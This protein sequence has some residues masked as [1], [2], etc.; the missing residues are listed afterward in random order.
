MEERRREII[1]TA[2]RLFLENG[3]DKT[4]VSDI[5]KGM[6]IAQGLVY[7]YFKS[8]AEILY[9]VVEELSREQIAATEKALAD[10]EGSALSRLSAL[11]SNLPELQ[12]CG[13]LLGDGMHDQG[14][15][16][17]CGTQMALAM[18]PLLLKLIKQGNADGS[19]QCEYPGETAAFI[20]HGISG[21]PD[22]ARTGPDDGQSRQAWTDILLRLLGPKPQEE[23]APVP[24]PVPVPLPEALPRRP[25]KAYDKGPESKVT[26]PHGEELPECLL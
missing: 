7:H 14:V 3:F 4:Q 10:I 24:S 21:I 25:A 22:P 2:G 1:E 19:W 11:L 9:A 17:Y 23:P 12:S 13:S 15:K 26:G 6:N 5:A 8:K 20:L 16:A 18:L